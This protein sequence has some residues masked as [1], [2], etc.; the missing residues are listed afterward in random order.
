MSCE[1]SGFGRSAAESHEAE[2]GQ[3]SGSA[4]K[5]RSVHSQSFAR[6]G[7]NLRRK[8]SCETRSLITAAAHCTARALLVRRRITQAREVDH[9]CSQ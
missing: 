1:V 8:A 6:R 7:L 3:A 5:R 4:E 9:V 2:H